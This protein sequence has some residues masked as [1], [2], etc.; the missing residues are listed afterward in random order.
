MF[1]VTVETGRR[2]FPHCSEVIDKFMEDD[3]P[4][5]C[6]LDRGTPDERRIKT[7]RFKEVKE[8]V[9]KAFSRDKAELSRSGLSSAS[10]T[11]SLR[12]HKTRKL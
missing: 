5:L 3:L 2:Y 6:Y 7:T 4:D 8:D 10:S 1:A 11:N 9:Q 12:H